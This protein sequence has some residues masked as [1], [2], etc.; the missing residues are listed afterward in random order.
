MIITGPGAN[1]LTVRRSSANF[2]PNFRIFNIT[3]GTVT[4]SGLTIANGFLFGGTDGGGI[5]NS[6]TLTFTACAISGN[7]AGTSSTNSGRGG[8]IAST[9]TLSITNS[10]ISGNSAAHGG[11]GIANVGGTATLIN[12]TVSGNFSSIQPGGGIDNMVGSLALTNCTISANWKGGGVLNDSG[13]VNV[14]NTII[15]KNTDNASD[16]L[17]NIASQG[18]NLVGVADGATMTP[19]TGDQIGTAA[20]P[21]DPILGPLQDN[22]GPTFTHALL[23]GS[24]ARDKGNS[25]GSNMDQ[26]GFAR[27][28]DN[29]FIR[30]ASGSDG[31]DI[32]AFEVQPGLT[33]RSL[34]ISTRA[35]V[36]TGDNVLIAGFI[37]TGSN[38][39][40]VVLRGLGP[41]LANA[42]IPPAT[43]LN[44][45]VLELH[46]A[47]GAL[48]S[49]ND[50]WK[51]SPQR[52]QI[53]GTVLQPTDDR[54]AVILTTL[55]PASYTAVIRGVGN[56]TGVGLVELYDVN[57]S[58]DSMLTNI[59]S[60]AFVEG[61]DNVVIAGF[62][63][64]GS[65]NGSP[66]IIIRGLGP[67]LA[68]FGITNPLA[69]PILQLRDA[70]GTQLASDDNWKNDPDQESEIVATG[71]QP[72]HDLEAA[73]AA[74]LPPGAYTAILFGVNGGTGVG[75]VE[76]YNLQ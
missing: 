2:T 54:E 41:S 67:S 23:G 58:S 50:N 11:G 17:G 70:N 34:N 32:G 25:T 76:V 36:Q 33:A 3:S 20:S 47:S 45:P 72:Q 21:L 5:S 63:L 19:V 66:L 1:V 9:G 8:G 31:S 13:S 65:S 49:A 56:S 14:R 68:T 52:A 53:Q 16:V 6:G 61:G 73:I 44:D 51:E 37:I 35:R 7:S 28:V 22:G 24:T 74:T 71:L 59:S 40:Q 43:V 29:P 26:R 12:C 39:K 64:G 10:T 55:S 69:N 57:Q 62:T 42:G 18:Y 38:P 60:R 48:L 75:L 4:I 27:P 46:G 30:N 15:A